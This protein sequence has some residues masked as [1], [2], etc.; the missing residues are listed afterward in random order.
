MREE[1]SSALQNIVRSQPR[2]EPRIILQRAEYTFPALKNDLVIV[3]CVCAHR[4]RHYK[5]VFP[6]NYFLELLP[7]NISPNL[8]NLFA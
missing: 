4:T 8:F 2:R 3:F 6:E 1:D 5:C 7:L